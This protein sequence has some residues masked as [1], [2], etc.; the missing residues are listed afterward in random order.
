MRGARVQVRLVDLVREE[1]EA[2]LLAEPHDVLHRRFVEQRASRVAWVDDDE[3]LGRDALPDGVMDRGL[4]VRR[5]RRPIG[6]LV[7][8]VRYAHAGVGREGCCV[9]RVLRDR[10]EDARAGVGD[11]HR[12]E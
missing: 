6:V 4:D 8:V 12:D 11:Q 3:R 10:D 9:Q 2:V 7:E 1:H 5:R